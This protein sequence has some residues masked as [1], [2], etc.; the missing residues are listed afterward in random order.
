MSEWQA[1]P[2]GRCAATR[3]GIDIIDHIDWRRNERCLGCGLVRRKAVLEGHRR[4][5]CGAC[6]QRI[7]LEEMCQS[8]VPDA[9]TTCDVCGVTGQFQLASMIDG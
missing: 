6:Y 8:G 5:E 2:C 1:D 3:W 9:T 4:W 7:V